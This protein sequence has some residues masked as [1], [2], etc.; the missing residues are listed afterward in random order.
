LG[1]RQRFFRFAPRVVHAD[2]DCRCRRYFGHVAV[3]DRAAS[4]HTRRPP[5]E[6]I[7]K[8]FPDRPCALDEGT[9]LEGHARQA[10]R[11]SNCPV[12]WSCAS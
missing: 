11:V 4:L 7:L 5:I 6:G 12:L 3:A 8:L 2:V 9:T 1:A 10:A